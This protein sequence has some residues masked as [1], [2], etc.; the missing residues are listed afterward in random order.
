MEGPFGSP[1]SDSMRTRVTAECTRI[2]WITF[3]PPGSRIPHE[4]FAAA[5]TRF[6]GGALN[7][8]AEL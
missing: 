1:I 4:E 7:F 3:A 5:V 6:N 8:S 2:V